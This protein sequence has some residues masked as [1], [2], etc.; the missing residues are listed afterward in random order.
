MRQGKG[1][2]ALQQLDERLNE[3]NNKFGWACR[4]DGGMD[5]DTG[6]IAACDDEAR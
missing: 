1:N 2:D 4:N 3:L 6:E 5:S